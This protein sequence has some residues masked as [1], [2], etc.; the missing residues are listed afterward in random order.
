MP[1]NFLDP[2]PEV[3]VSYENGHQETLFSYYPDEI[4]FSEDEFI[5]LTREEA[6]R[7]KIEKD[8]KYL[9]S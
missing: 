5:R 1:V 6:L 2:L 7:L 4:S 9:Q 3:I 8:K